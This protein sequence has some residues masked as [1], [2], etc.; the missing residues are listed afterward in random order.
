MASGHSGYPHRPFHDR[1]S[2]NWTIQLSAPEFPSIWTLQLSAQV[3]SATGHSGY[4]HK[5]FLTVTPENQATGHSS[6]PHKSSQALNMSSVSITVHLPR[7]ISHIYRAEISYAHHPVTQKSA[8][9]FSPL[10]ARVLTA[11]GF[12]P[13]RTELIFT[14]YRAEPSLPKLPAQICLQPLGYSDQTGFPKQR[15]GTQL[16]VI[17]LPSLKPQ[18]CIW[19]D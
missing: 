1:K 8:L 4:P 9:E 10:P 15:K 12:R 2:S 7:G 17:E 19:A 14:P 6:Y 13:S 18:L 3:P 16:L 5:D 11:S